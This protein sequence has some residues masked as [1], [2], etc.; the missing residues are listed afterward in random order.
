M[1]RSEDIEV[2][3]GPAELAGAAAGVFTAAARNAVE[4]RG[5]FTVALSG[6]STPLGLF[7]ALSSD[8]F[9]DRVPWSGVHLFWGDERCVPPDDRESNFRG[10]KENLIDRVD[11][12]EGNV[13][14]IKGELQPAKAAAAYESEVLDFFRER[15]L[16]LS[17]DTLRVP[18]LDMVILGLGTDG[19]TL[20]LFP[21]T[22]ALAEEKRLVV[23]NYVEGLGAWRVTMTLVLVNRAA[24]VVF[25][26][27][28]KEKAGAL[29][30]AF[31]AAEEGAAGPPASRVRPPGGRMRWIVDAAAA[32]GLPGR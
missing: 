1:K 8:E 24:E 16:P 17:G 15:K 27:S 18:V 2:V 20:S 21:G 19:H 30:R 22:R 23:D 3:D 32:A 4:G 9:R 11:V 26:V 29:V 10:A 25:L 5:V 13:H 28:G 7:H 12:P 31:S 14:R 6:G